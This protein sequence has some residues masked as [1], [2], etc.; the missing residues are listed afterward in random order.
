MG[1]P[2]RRCGVGGFAQLR[3]RGYGAH[4]REWW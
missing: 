4:R 2:S 3:T 1:P